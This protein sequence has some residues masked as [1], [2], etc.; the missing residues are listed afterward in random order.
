MAYCTGREQEK[1]F[2][3]IVLHGFGQSKFTDGGSGLGSS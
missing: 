2:M 1:P 3:Y